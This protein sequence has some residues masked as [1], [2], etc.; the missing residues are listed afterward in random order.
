MA[1]EGEVDGRLE[2]FKRVFVALGGNWRTEL[3]LI[4]K[5]AALRR[6][7]VQLEVQQNLPEALRLEPQPLKLE[8]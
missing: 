2:G 3:A 6:P 1:R 7:T 8:G 5:P 4:P